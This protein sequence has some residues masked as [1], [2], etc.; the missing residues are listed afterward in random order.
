MAKATQV[1]LTCDICGKAKDIKTRAFE[2]DGKAYE[3]D[4]CRKDGDAL[5]RVAA[6]YIAKARKATARPGRRQRGGRARAASS[7][8][9][10]K[11][12]K[13]AKAGKAAGGQPERGIYVYGI[14][15]ADIEMAADI[16]GVGAHPGLLRDIRHDGLVALVSEV[17]TAR[18]LGSPEDLR[19]YRE[20]LDATAA[21][22]PILPLRFGTVLAS[23]QAVAEELLA[24]GHDEFTAALERLEGCAQ[25]QVTACY[26]QDAVPSREEDTRAVRQAL[27]GVAVASVAREP[28]GER[29]LV[30]LALLVA[31]DRQGEAERVIADLA[32]EWEGRIDVRLQGPMAAYDFTG[33][34]QQES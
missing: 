22:V 13:A 34:A 32:R 24:A 29:D 25:F 2:L 33:P 28:A 20:I 10:A 6:R 15:P 27:E 9:T 1:T 30:D 16:P 31:A 17:D 12:A 5:G 19:T 18:P 8:R 3:I 23:D 21:E 4:L 11:T 26:A 14:L 7:G